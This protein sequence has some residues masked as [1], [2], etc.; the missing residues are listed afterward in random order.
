M[1]PSPTIDASNAPESSQRN[2]APDKTVVANKI[3]NKNS[4]PVNIDDN[5]E[6]DFSIVEYLKRTRA[7]ISLF[8]LANIARFCNEII[9]VLPGKMPKIPQ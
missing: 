8:E 5:V 9:N 7:S 1:N 4:S 2:N 6:L 3:V